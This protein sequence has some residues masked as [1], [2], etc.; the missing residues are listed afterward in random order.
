MLQRDV[1]PGIHRVEDNHT[2]FYL[3]EHDGGLT[4]VDA[5]IP[6]SWGSLHRALGE[7]GRT[8]D[9]LDA[10]ILTHA[11][12]DHI[13]MAERVRSE[14]G[15]DVWVH[16]RDVHL[17]KHPRDY[18]RERTPL[19]YVLT[20]PRALPIVAGFVATR[21][22]W[23]TPVEDVRPFT[24][25]TGPQVALAPRTVFTPGHTYGHVAFHFPDRDAVIA[26]DAVVMLN[27][28]T[29]S[30][31]PQIVARAATADTRQNLASLD[32]LAE[33]GART[34]L[35][36]HGDPWTDGAEA[37]VERARAAGPS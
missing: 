34:V 27:P 32:A 10:V 1:A 25:A 3:V 9:D 15:L 19:Y 8:T 33:T 7:L 16:E 12:F 5:G 23:P 21:G 24:E 18:D 14:L 29:G 17:T 22:M 2:N 31:G 11:H 13:G 4:I 6:T 37:I 30:R 26:G 36:G 28:Y 35:T 20:K